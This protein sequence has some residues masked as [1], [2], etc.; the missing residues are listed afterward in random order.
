MSAIRIA[1]AGELRSSFKKRRH[2][3][4]PTKNPKRRESRGENP[5]YSAHVF[6]V[7]KVTTLS[8]QG[9]QLGDA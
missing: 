1:V 8:F 5:Y 4:H 2:Q 3:P 9:Y 6:T 7:F